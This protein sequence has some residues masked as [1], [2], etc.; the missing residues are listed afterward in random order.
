MHPSPVP[1]DRAPHPEAEANRQRGA[2]LF[3]GVREYFLDQDVLPIEGRRRPVEVLLARGSWRHWYAPF[4]HSEIVGEFAKLRSADPPAIL[5]F[6]AVYGD[7]GFAALVTDP[8]DAF[9]VDA[10]TGARSQGGDPL[11]WIRAH[12]AG[13]HSCLLLTDALQRDA[14]KSTIGKLLAT[15]EDQAVGEHAEIYR[16]RL[17]AGRTPAAVARAVRNGILNPN[18]TGIYRYVTYDTKDKIDRSFFGFRA[19]VHVLYWHLANLIEGGTVKH[20]EAEGC[21]GLFI[22]SDPRQRYCPKR[23]RQN[24]SACSAR[25]RQRELRG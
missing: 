24:E 23:F 13:V 18:L 14:S 17:P 20:C 6:A 2:K 11:P 5:N 7:L 8:A 21:D 1:P 15:L 4:V 22:R 10:T 19:I 9:H 25:Q 3:C 16:L 12:A